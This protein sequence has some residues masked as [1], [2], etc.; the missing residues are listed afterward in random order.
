MNKQERME[1]G[2]EFLKDSFDTVVIIATSHEDDRTEF[3]A[4]QHG[5]E[6]ALGGS[7]QAWLDG[8]DFFMEDIGL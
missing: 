1:K 3:Y 5:N 4:E 2:L 8:E 6:Y 7:V